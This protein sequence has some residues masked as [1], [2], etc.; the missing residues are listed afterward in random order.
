MIHTTE[1]IKQIKYEEYYLLLQQNN[2]KIDNNKNIYLYSLANKGITRIKAYPQQIDNGYIYWCNI[3][4]NLNRVAKNGKQTPFPLCVN[5]KNIDNLKQN[6]E[7]FIKPLLANHSNIFDWIVQRI[8]YTID[9]QTTNVKEYIQLLQRGDKPYHYQIDNEK[10]HKKEIDKTHYPNSVRYKSKSATINIYNKYEE[11][12]SQKYDGII[13]EN[14]KNIL[15]LEIQCFKRK[16]IYLKQKYNKSISGLRAFLI[17]EE[18]QKAIFKY[19]ISRICGKANYYEYTKAIKRIE[20]SN[21]HQKTKYILKRLLQEISIHKSVWKAK[22]LLKPKNYSEYFNKL[23]K[24]N[25][26]PTTIPRRWAKNSMLNIYR[27]I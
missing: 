9:I 11:R 19:Y 15:R 23:E 17:S 16:A 7:N 1:L 21:L 14:C 26:N 24:L 22:L 5:E 12:K 18:Q 3:I 6:F 13:L 25:I 27:L 4:V 10:Q 20:E 8:D 2:V